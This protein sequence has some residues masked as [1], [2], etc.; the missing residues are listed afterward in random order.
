MGCI[1]FSLAARP[2]AAPSVSASVPW[3]AARGLCGSAAAYTPCRCPRPLV[4]VALLVFLTGWPCGTTDG[5]AECFCGT[6][7]GRAECPCGTT[8]GR[9]E[10]AG[11]GAGGS[12]SGS[13]RQ[14]CRIH[15]ETLPPSPCLCGLACF[16]RGSCTIPN[17]GHHPRGGLQPP[18]PLPQLLTAKAIDWQ[19]T[20]LPR[21]PPR[22]QQRAKQGFC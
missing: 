7:V 11:F 22:W 6:T 5:R 9:A 16:N 2:M 15:P 18:C 14:C 20:L 8:V 17:P 12:V 19:K 21:S 4:C 10:C 3:A 1:K 13:L